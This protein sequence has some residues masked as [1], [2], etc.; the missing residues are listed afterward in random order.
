MVLTGT[1][2][3]TGGTTVSG[4]VLRFDSSIPASGAA[5]LRAWVRGWLIA[6]SFRRG[7]VWSGAHARRAPKVLCNSDHS[8]LRGSIPFSLA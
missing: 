7:C 6:S 1:N 2:D 4:G 5:S 3:Y 8:Q